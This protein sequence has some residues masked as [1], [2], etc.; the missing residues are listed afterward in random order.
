MIYGIIEVMK[1]TREELKISQQR[2]PLSDF[3]ETYN[4]NMPQSFPRA[5]LSLLEKFKNEHLTLFKTDNLW[6]L[7]LHRKKLIDWL[8][9]NGGV[10]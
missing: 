7:D 10:V 5:S 6:S 3:L 9:R 1:N 8:P 2:I 4:K